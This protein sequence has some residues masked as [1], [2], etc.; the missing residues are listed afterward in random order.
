MSVILA[1]DIGGSKLAVGV[2]RKDGAVSS[3]RSIPTPRGTDGEALYQVFGDLLRQALSEA[4]PPASSARAIGVGCGGPMEYPEGVVSPLNIPAWR[5][6]PLRARLESDFQAPALVDNDA[7]AFA[8][9]EHW[10]GSGQGSRCLLAMVVSTGVGGGIV[11]GGRLIDGARGNA[12]HIGH[13]LAYPRGPRCPCGA[14]GCVEA[15]ASGTSLAAQARHAMRGGTPSRLPPNPTSRDLD[16]AAADGDE[17]ALSLFRRAGTALGRGI[18]SAASLFDLDRVVI[19]G[20][21]ANASRFFMPALR[22]EL[23]AR[24]RLDFTRDLP[25]EITTA[26]VKSSLAGAARLVMQ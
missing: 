14:R 20:G 21:V 3:D 16:A 23:D 15:V 4:G 7:K 22:R 18:A 19:G 1:A 12:G 9:G 8:L 10:V 13:V 11:Q 26:T 25:V 6:F 5:G 2:V 24:A 17:L